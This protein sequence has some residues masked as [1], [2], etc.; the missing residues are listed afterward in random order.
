[1]QFVKTVCALKIRRVTTKKHPKLSFKLLFFRV[2]V[3][4]F[5][6]VRYYFMRYRVKL[7]MINSNNN[8]TNFLHLLNKK[9]SRLQIQVSIFKYKF[10]V[11]HRVE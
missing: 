2:K 4:F 1:M 5:G 10:I 7:V 8:K 9:R 11:L 6:A 3:T